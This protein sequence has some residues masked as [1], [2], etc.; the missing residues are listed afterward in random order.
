MRN[1]KEETS[2]IEP[3]RIHPDRRRADGLRSHF[4]REHTGEY[5][6]DALITTKVKSAF[7]EDRTVTALDIKVE[8]CNSQPVLSGFANTPQEIDRAIQLARQVKGVE[9]VKNKI[10]L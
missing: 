9:P 3:R 5:I 4:Y 7:V 1:E 6:D 10:R 2:C 8:T